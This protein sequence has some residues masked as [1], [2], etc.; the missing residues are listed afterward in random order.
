M[1]CPL[2]KAEYREGI[3][4]CEDCNVL[5]VSALPQDEEQEASSGKAEEASPVLLW[6]GENP[7]VYTAIL[8]A[9]GEAGIEFYDFVA[10]DYEA[11]LS[12]GFPLSSTPGFEIRVYRRDAGAAKRILETVLEQISA[13]PPIEVQAEW[14][15]A[16]ADPVTQ[17]P[18]EWA[19]EDAIAEAWSGE[20]ASV[21][22]FVAAA[23]RENG[24]PSRL[25]EPSGLQRLLVRPED[26]PRA[27][28]IIREGSTTGG[29]CSVGLRPA[30][31]GGRSHGPEGCW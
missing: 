12:L 22:E 17:I 15:P 6:R 19:P 11:Q 4:R 5:L 25:D 10:R 2:C 28:A 18:E 20:D 27:R 3:Y 24:I 31:P 1:F 26:L 23:L 13:A 16:Q 8:N 30:G 9:L 29:G 21:A 14:S 7:V